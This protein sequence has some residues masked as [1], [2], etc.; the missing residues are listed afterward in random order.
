MDAESRPWCRNDRVLLGT[1]LFLLIVSLSWTTHGHYDARNDSSLYLLVTQSLLEGEGMTYL[2]EPFAIR[3]PG[4]TVLLSPVVALFG[5]DAG[6]LNLYVSFWGVALVLLLYLYMR[7]ITG[8]SLAFGACVLAWLAPG[9]QELC[10]QAMSDIPGATLLIAGLLIERVARRKGAV[11]N[12]GLGLFIGLSALVRTMDV[13]LLPA[14]IGARLIDEAARNRAFPRSAN[15]WRGCGAAA[16]GAGLMVVPWALH[17]TAS[18]PEGR[19]DQTHIHSYSVA[20]WHQDPAD[21]ASPE[22]SWRE[23]FARTNDRIPQTVAAIGSRLDEKREGPLAPWLG[24]AAL[25]AVLASF[26]RRRGAGELFVLGSLLV[27]G[28]YFAFK[29]RLVLP[30]FLLGVAA[31]AEALALL[32]AKSPRRRVYEHGLGCVLL[33]VAGL[34]YRPPQLQAIEGRDRMRHEVTAR[35]RE[36]TP[37]G[38]VLAASTGWDL[39][40][41][42]PERDTVS[43]RFAFKQ[44]GGPGLLRVIEERGVQFLA[45]YDPWQEDKAILKAL[46]RLAPDHFE[47]IEHFQ[48]WVILKDTR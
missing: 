44:E 16:L 7:P 20:Q 31:S 42:L 17:A 26:M 15:L 48:G 33:L 5:I 9:I 30:L 4:F 28:T 43:L 25:L 6:A 12:L 18:A 27:V 8:G 34:F 47:L 24:G 22:V 37:P 19:T 36:L 10:N 14:V 35:L 23:F 21:P 1:L 39:G 45:L 46:S 38:S 13:L 41:Y 11:A 29:P 32:V 3:P 2:G 40:V